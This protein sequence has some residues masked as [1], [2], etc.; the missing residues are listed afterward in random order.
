MLDLWS[1]KKME[2]FMGMTASGV[3]SDSKPFTVLVACRKI[4][5]K[6]TAEKIAEEYDEIMQKWNLSSKVKTNI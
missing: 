4:E 3:G 2:G 5:G 1:S 6:H